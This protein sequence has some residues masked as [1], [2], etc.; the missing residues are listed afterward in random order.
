MDFHILDGFSVK[1]TKGIKLHGIA[2]NAEL[3]SDGDIELCGMN[4]QGT[5]S[6]RCGGD[7][8]VNFCNDTNIVCEG[9][10]TAQVEMRSCQVRCMGWLRIIKGTFGGGSCIVLSGIE[11]GALGTK[12]SMLTK[13]MVGISYYDFDE[14]ELL[15][16]WLIDL[17]ERFTSTPVEKRNL[18]S[19]VAERNNL[20]EQMQA[21]RSRQY[22]ST[23]PKINV[24]RVV[25]ENADTR[26]VLLP[27]AGGDA[28]AD[29]ID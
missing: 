29:V 8:K 19:F 17:N 20:T 7:L 18:A 21:V 10:I 14:I 5:G 16:S 1:A 9:T 13:V 24:H 12:T 15:N 23:N 22:V 6:I 25:Y 4:G 3:A 27:D 2:G 28:G 11:T 26:A